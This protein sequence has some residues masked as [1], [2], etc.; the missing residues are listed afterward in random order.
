M[1]T[2]LISFQRS[3]KQKFTF[4]RIL[5]HIPIKNDMSSA[6]WNIRSFMQ[7]QTNFCGHFICSI[8]C[9]WISSDMSL[10]RKW[11]LSF[12]NGICAIFSFAYLPHNSSALAL[13]L[14]IW[15]LGLETDYPD[16]FLVFYSV[17]PGE[18]WESTL[19]LGH[20]HFLPNSL[21][22]YHPFNATYP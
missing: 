17:H 9:L 3:I 14:H 22:T 7:L 13:L 18:F 2:A 19:K 1:S 5:M 16:R 15:D 10:I 11:M 20:N 21:F 8:I 4:Y 6:I 12:D